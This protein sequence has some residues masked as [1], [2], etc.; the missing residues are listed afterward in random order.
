MT[1]IDAN[2][3]R[4][5]GNGWDIKTKDCY[6]HYSILYNLKTGIIYLYETI[7]NNKYGHT[8]YNYTTYVSPAEF[9]GQHCLLCKRDIRA[10]T[11]ISELDAGVESLLYCYLVSL[12]ERLRN[13]CG[14][15]ND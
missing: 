8:K 13:S 14:K 2:T 3:L 10:Y 4:L 15:Q 11:D 5:N 7:Q 6:I 1:I 9:V 12:Q